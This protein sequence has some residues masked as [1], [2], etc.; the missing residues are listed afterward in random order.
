VSRCGEGFSSLLIVTVKGFA[1]CDI[2]E[3]YDFA[4]M[5]VSLLPSLVRQFKERKIFVK[6]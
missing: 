1:D 5:G 6:E 4:V 2:K 3:T